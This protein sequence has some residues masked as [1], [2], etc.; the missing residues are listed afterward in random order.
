M[1]F[2][3]RYLNP[4]LRYCYFRFPKTNSRRIGIL[5]PVSI[6]T[7]LLS[8]AC[9]LLP[10]YEISSKSINAWQSCDVISIFQDGS[11]RVANLLLASIYVCVY[12]CELVVAAEVERTTLSTQWR[13]SVDDAATFHGKISCW[14]CARVT[15]TSYDC[16]K[17]YMM[18]CVN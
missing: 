10:T 18:R 3:M 4:W 13:W 6:L 17:S 15:R 7:N 11:R 1:C 8:S 2:A 9:H 14:V 12:V 16:T 5:L